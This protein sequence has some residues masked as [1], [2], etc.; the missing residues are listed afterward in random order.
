MAELDPRTPVIIGAAQALWRTGNAPDPITMM[1]EVTLAAADDAGAGAALLRRAQT[2]AAVESVSR[3]WQDPAAL[4]ASQLGLTPRETVR[5]SLGGDAPHQLVGDLATRI[6][7][8]ERD[9]GVIVGAE[10]LATLAGALKAGA[11]PDGWPK[12]EAGGAPDRVVGVD[13]AGSSDAENAV[14]LIAPLM[15]YPL[16]EQALWARNAP[17]LGREAYQLHLGELAAGFARVAET[18]P[19]AWSP[20]PRTAEEIATPSPA[21]RQVTLPYT[22]L[23]NA[24]IQTD[25]AAALILCSVETARGLGVPG[26][27][28]VFIHGHAGAHDRWHV[29]ERA[30][31][32][33]SP[34][35]R[36]SGQAALGSAGAGIDEIGHLDIYSCFP[37]AVQIGAVELGIEPFADIREL[38]VT[39]GLTF[40]GGPGNNYVTHSIAALIGRLREHPHDLGLA[41]AVGWYLTKHGVGIY[42]ARPPSSPFRSLSAQDQVDALPARAVAFPYAGPATAESACV[43]YERDGSPSMAM[44]TALRGDGRRVLGSSNEPRALAEMLDAPIAGRALR[45]AADGAVT[46]EG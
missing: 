7:S 23:L 25:Q 46:F 2:I 27:R 36:L 9:A 12:L 10:A 1:A 28:W 18:N 5:S 17:Q 32:H 29:S 3:R 37:S 8:G 38:S 40:A 19:Y 11:E 24:N 41:T 26:D 14:G 16:F 4:V 45:L 20:E 22:K 34:A 35:I 15:M 21:N 31:L 30:D 44:L 13:R 39:G 43:M 6:A 42:G 33:S